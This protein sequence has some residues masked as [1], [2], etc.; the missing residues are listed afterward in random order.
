MNGRMK[1]DAAINP[2]GAEM[3]KHTYG[4]RSLNVSMWGHRY[5]RIG[6]LGVYLDLY[7]YKRFPWMWR[8]LYSRGKNAAWFFF[9]G[10]KLS[11]P[12]PVKRGD[13]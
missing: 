6:V 9:P 2:C 5:I 10:G 7:H 12:M 1:I 4:W 8:F 3:D 13:Y 11:W